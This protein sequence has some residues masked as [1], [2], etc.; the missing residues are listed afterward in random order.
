[1]GG[2]EEGKGVEEVGGGVKGRREAG[3]KGWGVYRRGVEKDCR[4]F[5]AC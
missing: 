2:K 4:A 1:V 5:M 3:G